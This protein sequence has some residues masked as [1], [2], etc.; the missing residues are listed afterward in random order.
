MGLPSHSQNIYIGPALLTFS[1]LPD[2]S[3]N[4]LS[5]LL[6]SSLHFKIIYPRQ[7]PSVRAN[8]LSPALC[9]PRFQ[10]GCYLS[11]DCPTEVEVSEHSHISLNQFQALIYSYLLLPCLCKYLHRQI[12]SY[13]LF[14]Y[15]SFASTALR[16]QENSLCVFYLLP[17]LIDE[18]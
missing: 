1:N 16:T 12:R 13:L 3:K 4:S 2:S 8:F 17:K 15:I 6:G 7:E 5:L 18:D 11:G 9:N 10:R 14:T